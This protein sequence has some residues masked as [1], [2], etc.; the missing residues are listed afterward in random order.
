MPIAGP[1]G[2]ALGGTVAAYAKPAV[3]DSVY[4]DH[5]VSWTLFA[6]FALGL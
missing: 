6:K 1:F 3:L 2:V 4:G 5:P